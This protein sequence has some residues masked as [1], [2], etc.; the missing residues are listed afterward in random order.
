M[1]YGNELLEIEFDFVSHHCVSASA[2]VHLGTPCAH[3]WRSLP[4][5]SAS[6]AAMG[7]T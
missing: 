5:L 3:Q 7:V 1:P 6:L 4:R 2:T